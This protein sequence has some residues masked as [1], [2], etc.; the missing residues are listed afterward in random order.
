MKNKKS[1]KF[2]I[3]LLVIVVFVAGIFIGKVFSKNKQSNEQSTE[4]TTQ[5]VEVEVG[6]QTLENTLTSSGE[7]SASS[8]EK[9]SLST[10]KYFNTMCVEQGDIVSSGENI[11]EYKD[12]TYLTAEYDCLISTYSVPE[13][14]SKATSSNYIEVQNIESM[15]MNLSISE[16]EI[17]KVAKGQEVT[18]T[19]S[20]IDN[21]TYSGTIKSVSGIGTYQSSGTTFTAVVEFEN[22]GNVKPGMSATCSIVV[23]KA[24]NC[25]AV[26]ID[27]VQT[28]NVKLPI[29]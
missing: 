27:S 7:I 2:L 21:K 13:T 25:I 18:I 28:N 1:K 6:T 4:T 8:T 23:E 9:I 29:K 16:S 22:D 24:E 15:T 11:L 17:N 3:T 19:L 26:P 12:G 14:G 10:S 20:A 5:I